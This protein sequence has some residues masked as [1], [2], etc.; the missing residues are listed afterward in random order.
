MKP[1]ELD[2]VSLLA[3]LVFLVLGGVG[4]LQGAGVIGSGAPWAVIGAV[5]AVGV[6]G[7][8]VSLRRLAS[9]DAESGE[10]RSPCGGVPDLE[11]AGPHDPTDTG[12]PGEP[13]VT[14]PGGPGGLDDTDPD[15][16]APDIGAAGAADRG[17]PGGARGPGAGLVADD[18]RG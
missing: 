8:V 11:H 10:N 4:L 1:H 14:D 18:R 13:D 12:E 15:D 6:T 2:V 9:T 16:I 3:G 17:V 5:A 7:L